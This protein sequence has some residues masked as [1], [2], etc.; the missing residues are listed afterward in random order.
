MT[1]S[2]TAEHCTVG[3][4]VKLVA[5]ESPFNSSSL[6]MFVED[7]VVFRSC[8]VQY[9]LLFS[10]LLFYF[11]VLFSCCVTT[12][13]SFSVWIPCH[14]NRMQNYQNLTSQRRTGTFLG[15]VTLLEHASSVSLSFGD[16]EFN[17]FDKTST[18][19][20]ISYM[21]SCLEKSKAHELCPFGSVFVG[22]TMSFNCNLYKQFNSQLKETTSHVGT[23]QSPAGNE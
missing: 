15:L 16:S 5:V 23:K 20:D 22:L 2:C 6:W 13:I 19:R 7:V 21:H 4:L 17:I 12:D 9:S 18:D 1:A 3:H 11:F 10:F 14:R 8:P